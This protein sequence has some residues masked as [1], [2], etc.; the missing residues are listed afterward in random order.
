M[1]AGLSSNPFASLKL[2][3]PGSKSGSFNLAG[4][5]EENSTLTLPAKPCWTQ[6]LYHLNEHTTFFM[7]IS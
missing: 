3:E 6:T 4:G 1:G 7:S 2:K 5:E